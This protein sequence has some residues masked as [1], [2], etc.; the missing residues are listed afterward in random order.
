[1]LLTVLMAF[2]G[3]QT[4]GATT[5]DGVSYIDENGD[6]Q[7]ANGVTVLTGSESSLGSN[8]ATTWYVVN[9]NIS[10]S[11][12]IQCQGNVNIILADG[13]TM[14]T[15]NEGYGASCI[16]GDGGGT[17]TIYGQT[18]G[19]GTLEASIS[20]G[21]NCPISHGGNVVICGGTVNVT[22]SGLGTGIKATGSVTLSGGKV[23]VITNGGGKVNVI[24]NGGGTGIEGGSVTISGGNVSVSD[25][26]IGIGGSGITISGGT[27]SAITTNGGIWVADGVTINGGT[28]TASGQYGIMSNLADVTINGGKVTAT[29]SNNG[30]IS[31]HGSITLGLTNTDD[32]IKAS[33]YYGTVT[34]ATGLTLYGGFPSTSFTGTIDDPS[35]LN[36]L[37][38]RPS[39]AVTESGT[40]EYTIWNAYGWEA[41]CD[42]LLDNDTYNRFSGKTVCLGNDIEVTRMAGSEGNDFCGTFDGQGH[43][44]DLNL[45][46]SNGAYALFCNVENGTI[47]NLHVTG[48][49][50][51]AAQYA[52]GLISGLWGTVNIENCT[53][54]VTI[55]SGISGDGTHAG[56]VAAVNANSTL[57]FEGCLFNG[58]LLTT[59]SNARVC[60]GFVGNNEGTVTI[61]NCLYAP[62]A[63]ADGETWASTH[64]SAT[65][66][67]GENGSDATI[68]NSYYTAPPSGGWGAA[69]GKQIR[70]IT[71]GENVTVAHAGMPTTYSVSGITAYKAS[72]G[73]SSF[74]TGIKYGGVLYAGSGDYVSLTLGNTVTTA[75][76]LPAGYQYGGNY[77]ASPGT[78]SGSTLTMPE[79]DVTVTV[80]VDTETL[81]PIDWTT[82]NDGTEAD[83]YV[84]YNNDQ[85]DLLAQRVNW[86]ES[87]EGK[88][89]VL[90]D[91]I[92]YSHTTDWDDATST[93]NNYTAIGCHYSGDDYHLFK[94]HFDGQGHTV[95][96]I[97]IYKSGNYNIMDT[98]FQ[99]LF[100]VG[101]EEAVIRGIT[102]ADTRITA[103]WYVGG[104]V[105][106][107]NSIVS[108]CHASASV[109]LHSYSD[110]DSHF[111]GI[112]GANGN[113][114]K[115]N[116]SISN[117]TSAA[118]I[119][120]DGIVLDGC[121][122]IAGTNSSGT[123]RH[124]LAIKAVVPATYAKSHGAICGGN[125][126]GG[127]LDGNFN[128]ACD[129]ASNGFND[130][131][132][133]GIILYDHSSRK[134][135]NSYILT[136]V[137]NEAVSHVALA[138]RTLTKNGEWNTLCLPFDVT[139]EQMAVNTHPLYGATIKQLDAANSN[140]AA[141]GTLT[142]SFTTANSIEAGTPYIVR[143]GTPES[144]PG[145]SIVDPVF[146]DVT[147]SSTTPTAVNFDG[148]KFVGQYSP[149]AIDDSNINSIIM[150]GS[151]STL[152]YS[153]NPR[154]LRSFRA[155][156]EIPTSTGAP[157]MNSFVMNFG[158][159]EQTGIVSVHSSQ[160]IVHSGADAWFT[161]D[162]RKLDGKPT[163]KGLY[164]VNG[165]KVVVK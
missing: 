127:T 96:G 48:N 87:Y 88:Y 44:I 68:T 140:L 146:T 24:T 152:G 151:G 143:W 99:G 26:I 111:G 97:R 45:D 11:G 62:A 77:S 59:N 129:V 16:S 27:V 31:G 66:V 12:L 51:T 53:S 137:G 161:L 25:A 134:D 82:V 15:S 58:K 95:S 63:L 150:L 116:G 20:S 55:K 3:A 90:G 61:T 121:G 160:F 135:L 114:L 46:S 103:N 17:L 113:N 10:H 76:D 133:S 156:F 105:G 64:L 19:S 136:T 118:I 104:I 70:S 65:F 14:T 132:V 142:L 139:A 145:G 86:G 49:I 4:A 106:S 154:T 115:G 153:K 149:F 80:I 56:F 34:V 112:V 67:S 119:T 117:C 41:F 13:Y 29:G 109:A 78:L 147:I 155:H 144:N 81:V 83:P 35:A 108:D 73:S 47:E 94:G 110:Y 120:K 2:A 74:I 79:A 84:I 126:D 158:D 43:T 138:D 125:D 32:F 21:D 37:T 130:Y 6:S 60:G 72:T 9:S 93:E 42:A 102:L 162:G 131:A 18:L 36:G 98:W 30:I 40:N 101:S 71:A 123:L 163:K 124:N 52:A 8:G 89:F 92:K 85:L 75:T 69:Q 141:N 128:Y 148:G 159:D 100:G 54:S 5:I 57:N 22:K 157:A 39:A 38:L 91:D 7:T 165:K 122:G 107:S 33:S 164:I 23:N 1:M 50:N 28:V